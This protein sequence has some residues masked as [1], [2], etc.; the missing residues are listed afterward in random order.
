MRVV[1]LGPNSSPIVQMIEDSLVATHEDPLDVDFVHNHSVELLVSF[2]YRHIVPPDVLTALQHR[3]LNIHISYLPWNRGSDPNFWSW[4]T[5]TPKGVS[6][7]WMSSGLDKGSLIAKDQIELDDSMT[8]RSS[9]D[10]L[11]ASAAQLFRSHWHSI[12]GGSASAIKQTGSGSYHSSREKEKYFRMLSNGW[13]TPC[14]EV[15]RI[16]NDLGLWVNG[17]APENP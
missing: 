14:S 8:L 10:L 5:N 15:L 6:I 4:L 12:K 2:G 17:A 7:H 11:Q 3:A 1:F 13:D 16:G 9:Y